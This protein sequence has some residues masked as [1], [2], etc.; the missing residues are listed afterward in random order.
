MC[1]CVGVCVLCAAM[2]C[3]GARPST[4]GITGRGTAHASSPATCVCECASPGREARARPAVVCAPPA[5]R[6]VGHEKEGMQNSKQSKKRRASVRA[7]AP[8]G[9][10]EHRRRDWRGGA[11]G[12]AGAGE[13]A[14]SLASHP[15][16]PLYVCVCVKGRAPAP[17]RPPA[18]L[19]SASRRPVPTGCVGGS[20]EEFCVSPNK[21]AHGGG[22]PPWEKEGGCDGL[23]SPGPHFSLFF[24]G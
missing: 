3:R 7:R 20:R 13:R 4:S 2:C 10:R 1:V 18:A 23:G 17:R 5:T 15:S 11:R 8:G 12:G 6:T 9:E 14:E 22:P 24:P 16:S 19:S 21:M